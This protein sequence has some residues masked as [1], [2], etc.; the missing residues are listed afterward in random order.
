M[1][2]KETIK[3]VNDLLIN[4]VEK[5]KNIEKIRQLLS[6]D[7]DFD[8]HQV[9]THIDTESKNYINEINLINF[10]QKKNGISCTMEE[11]KFLIFFYDQNFD[12]KLSYP[13]FL[14]LVLCENNYELRKRTRE[15]YLTLYGKDILPF[16]TEY[17][18]V[19]LLKAELDLIRTTFNFLY[20]LKSRKDFNF[21]E[22]YNYMKGY[23]CITFQSMKLFFQKSFINL[24]EEDIRTIFKRLDINKDNKINFN[25]FQAFFSFPNL[26]YTFN[27]LSNNNSYKNNDIYNISLSNLDMNISLPKVNNTNKIGKAESSNIKGFNSDNNSEM[28]SEL[29]TDYLSS[30]LSLVPSI[31]RIYNPN[32]KLLNINEKQS[33]NDSNMILNYS[34]INQIYAPSI[35]NITYKNKNINNK[36]I[37]NNSICILERRKICEFCNNY[38]CYCKETEFII[39]EKKFLN[40]LSKLIEIES[41]IEEEKINLIMH[42]D[43]NIEDAFR[44]FENPEKENLSI[45]EFKKGLNQIGINP[46]LKEIRLLIK[47]ADK[48]KNGIIN[49][50]ELFDLLV[51][52][53]KQYRENVEKRMPSSFFSTNNKDVLFLLSTKKYLG[54]LFKTII[55]YEVQ[56]NKIKENLSE[57]KSQIGIIFNKIDYSGLGFISD[58]ELFIYLE[59]ARIKCNKF[60]NDLIFIRFD[61]NKDGRIEMWEIE[62]ELS[63]S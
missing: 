46:S 4:L 32:Q 35:D 37:N 15:C 6:Q 49:Y 24:D 29:E 50:S 31:K 10:L 39:G 34:T 61:K 53:Q 1:L 19:K 59:N 9:F 62:E 8:A 45:Y 58:M 47:R 57:V 42:S 13:E 20:E 21:Q 63:P 54:N 40:Y 27:T 25:E 44:L 52:F 7:L 18:I 5:E 60:Q 28:Y 11:I 56:L 3:C 22:L 38:P 16:N 48:K 17:I 51:P 30:S 33:I 2:S 41:K 14:N 36:K 26:N 12:G 55:S 43:F 23:G